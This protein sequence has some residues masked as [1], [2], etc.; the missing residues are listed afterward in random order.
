MHVR[1]R[2]RLL[3]ARGIG[4]GRCWVPGWQ[5]AASFALTLGRVFPAVSTCFCLSLLS[6][7]ETWEISQSKSHVVH[8]E[9]KLCICE[10]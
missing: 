7:V 4:C 2:K 1:D 8:L 3:G 10:K 9:G 5:M 6:R